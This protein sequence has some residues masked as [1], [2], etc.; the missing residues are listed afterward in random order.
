MVGGEPF[1]MLSALDGAWRIVVRSGRI[2]TTGETVE[3]LS[4]EWRSRT[5]ILGTVESKFGK[6]GKV[7]VYELD[8]RK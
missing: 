6:D 4:D 1:K 3:H 7:D 8:W 5:R 2:L